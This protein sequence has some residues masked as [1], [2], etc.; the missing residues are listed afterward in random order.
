MS[1]NPEKPA[2][3]AGNLGTPDSCH[4]DVTKEYLREFLKVVV[5]IRLPFIP[6]DV[7]I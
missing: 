4:G 1:K 7:V 6:D 2:V 5:F 3:P